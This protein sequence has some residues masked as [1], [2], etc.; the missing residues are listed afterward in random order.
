MIAGN[1]IETPRLLLMSRNGGRTP[2][3]V[4]NSSD[5][6][7]RN[8]MDHPYL[9]AWGMSPKPTLPIS[10]SADHLGYRRSVRG[11]FRRERGAFRVDIGNEGWNFVVRRR[12]EHDDARFHQRYEPEPKR[13]L[14]RGT[15]RLFGK[16]LMDRLK[17]NLRINFAADSSSSR[18]PDPAIALRCPRTSPTVSAFR[19]RKF[20][21]MSPTIP[22][23]GSSRPTK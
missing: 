18:A 14:G 16:A 21:M 13:Q 19:A 2:N 10:R 20:P 17:R 15:R 5:M 22:G 4:A 9:V 3:G 12:S 8:L 11:P 23:R 1:A 6:V 7:G